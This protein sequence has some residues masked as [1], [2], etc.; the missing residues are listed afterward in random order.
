MYPLLRTDAQPDVH[1]PDNAISCPAGPV[2]DFELREFSNKTYHVYRVC[3]CCGARSV[4]PVK[5]E[6]ISIDIRRERLLKSGR[7]VRRE[8]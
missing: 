3:S 2:Y 8:I 7:E 1:F 6:T 4:S 5:R